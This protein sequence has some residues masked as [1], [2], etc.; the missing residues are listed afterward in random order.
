MAEW[1]VSKEKARNRP[2]AL[3]L[4]AGLLNEGFLLPTGDLA[5]DAAE[6]ADQ[7]VFSDDPDA[8]YYF[9]SSDEGQNRFQR[10]SAVFNR[11]DK[12]QKYFST[13]P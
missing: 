12:S 1:L 7:T 13:Y 6:S 9:V 3:V 10:S 5:K 11:P 8:L 2:E 4:A